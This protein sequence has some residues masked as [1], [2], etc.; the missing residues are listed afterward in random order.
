MRF[1]TYIALIP[2][3]LVLLYILSFGPGSA[4]LNR[5][6]PQSWQRFALL[7]LYQPL[8]KLLQHSPRWLHDATWFLAT[9]FR[10]DR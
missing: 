2:P 9:L 1:W 8:M 6:E 7:D 10:L 5:T 3:M 4:I